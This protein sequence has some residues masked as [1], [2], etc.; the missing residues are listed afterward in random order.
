MVG[1]RNSGSE[2]T[3]GTDRSS[4]GDGLSTVASGAGLILGGRVVK[5]VL[6]FG[7]QILMARLL[8][9]S[10]YGGVVLATTVASM[11]GLIANLGLSAG[12]S[13]NLP[14]YE[15]D[16]S[17]ARGVVKQSVQLGLISGGIM[18]VGLFLGAPLLAEQLFDDPDL[19]ILF[20]VAALTIPVNFLT[21]IAIEAAR[22]MRDAGT[23][24]IVKQLLDPVVRAGFVGILLFV[25]LGA[26]GAV[27]GLL[28]ASTVSAFA[29]VILAYRTLSFPV[30]GPT[31]RMYGELLAFSFPLLLAA[32]M[33]FV[34]VNTDTFLIGVFLDSNNVAV[35][36]AVFQL[37]D[38]GL[39]FFYP[40]TFLLPPVLTRMMKLGERDE[41][42]KIYQVASK[43]LVLLT[44]P[45]FLPII[46]FPE[47][48]IGVTFGNEYLWG[49]LSLQ[50]LMLPVMVTVLLSANSAAL[51]ALGH[52]RVNMYV[53]TA[54]ALLNVALNVL[55]IPQIGIVGAALASACAMITRDIVYAIILYRREALHPFSSALLR[56]FVGS[57]FIA[58]LGYLLVTRILPITPVNVAILGL[59][60]LVI[61]GPILITLGAL[62]P[63]DTQLL[64]LLEGR[65][66]VEFTTVRRLVRRMS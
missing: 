12:I 63:E 64:S 5:L 23:H 42:T 41:A 1:E 39:L 62:E 66:G 52:S 65:I 19:T 25:G 40:I 32:G 15:D 50:V 57:V 35:Y 11:S 10:S 54:M 51:I 16:P 61:Y 34:I 27:S 13:R 44:T 8:G 2:N 55:L 20:Q 31:T 43:W 28:I 29:A 21:N 59:A 24:V 53:N 3:A 46:F 6:A 48:V 45:V 22:G 4:S 37:Q 47:V 18:S 38:T 33:D 30:R 60:F 17:K 58:S 7:L 14:Y 49:A 9:P 26:L 36:N 56:P